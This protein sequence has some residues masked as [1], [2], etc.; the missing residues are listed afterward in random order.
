MQYLVS[1]RLEQ[2]LSLDF[3][4]PLN[5]VLK[6]NLPWGT[7]QNLFWVCAIAFLKPLQIF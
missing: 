7:T 1:R 4:L 2:W 3:P 6:I 5:A